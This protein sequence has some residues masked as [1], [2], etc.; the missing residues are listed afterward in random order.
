[1][2]IKIKDPKAKAILENLESLD[3]IEITDKP[4]PTRLPKGRK[5]EK[6][7]THLAS[8]TSLA[9]AWNNGKEDQ[10]WQALEKVK[11]L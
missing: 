1:M 5:K 3:L 11:W 7:E 4:T 8:E 9:K 2:F 10:E 6:T